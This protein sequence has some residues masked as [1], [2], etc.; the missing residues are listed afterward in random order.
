[1]SNHGI[2]Q[3]SI[4]RFKHLFCRSIFVD[5]DELSQVVPEIECNFSHLQ[6][7]MILRTSSNA[8]Y[9]KLIVLRVLSDENDPHFS[10]F[11]IHSDDTSEGIRVSGK[12]TKLRTH[13]TKLFVE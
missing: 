8:L 2:Y 1:M 10:S 12:C 5:G 13:E 4:N 7:F 3:P 9:E 11:R 6:I